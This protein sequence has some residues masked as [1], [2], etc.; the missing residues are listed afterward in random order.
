MDLLISMFRIQI[1]GKKIEPLNWAG[2]QVGYFKAL[3]DSFENDYQSWNTA[4]A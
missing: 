3:Y 4:K 1:P 2:G